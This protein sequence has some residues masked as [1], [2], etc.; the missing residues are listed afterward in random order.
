MRV[1]FL[2]VLDQANPEQSVGVRASTTV[3]TQTLTLTNSSFVNQQAAKLAE[4][5]LG[6][7]G[8]SDSAQVDRL[9]QLALQRAPTAEELEFALSFLGEQ[10]VAFS[11]PVNEIVFGSRVPDRLQTAY[12]EEI[13][14][15]AMLYGPTGWQY[16][17]GSWESEYNDTLETQSQRGPVAL[18]AEISLIDTELHFLLTLSA[19]GDRASVLLRG[20]PSGS[21]YRGISAVFDSGLGEISIVHHKHPDLPSEV[22]ARRP[23][24]FLP[25]E[26]CEVHINLVEGEYPNDE[27]VMEDLKFI[28]LDLWQDSQGGCGI[29]T[30]KVPKTRGARFGLSGWGQRVVFS[31]VELS[32]AHHP[33]VEPMSWP[34]TAESLAMRRDVRAIHSTPVDIHTDALTSLALVLLNTN[35]FLYIE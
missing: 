1:P 4:R 25:G 26:A 17:K 22:L 12:L 5:A 27:G 7:A 11:R 3:P 34:F 19:K 35:E 8:V 10:R 32:A 20:S 14:A 2:E 24:E 15:E 13:D 21:D 6:E 9:F 29:A 28:K 23:V 33:F 16:L 31:E 30:T 18:H